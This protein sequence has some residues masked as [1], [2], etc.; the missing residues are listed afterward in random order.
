VTLSNK[1]K[2]GIVMQPCERCNA[3]SL[4]DKVAQAKVELPEQ[5]KIE[6]ID[7][8]APDYIW[9]AALGMY[10]QCVDSGQPIPASFMGM[11]SCGELT[12]E[13]HAWAE[14]QLAGMGIPSIV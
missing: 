13:D 3:C 4:P 6:L 10:T 2:K 7:E 1:R 5:W 9:V 14:Q 11:L 8:D 12:D